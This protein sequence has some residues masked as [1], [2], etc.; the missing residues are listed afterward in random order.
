MGKKYWKSVRDEHGIG[1]SGE[2]CGDN[3]TQLGRIDVLH[4]VTPFKTCVGAAA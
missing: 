1:S 4:H 3:E 2:Y